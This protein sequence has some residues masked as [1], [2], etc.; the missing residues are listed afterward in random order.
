[1]GNIISNRDGENDSLS[2][3]VDAAQDVDA[4]VSAENDPA[5]TITSDNGEVINLGNEPTNTKD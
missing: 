5:S 2:D 1:M 3:L 4:P